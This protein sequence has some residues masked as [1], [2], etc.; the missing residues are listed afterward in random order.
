MSSQRIFRI[1]VVHDQK[2]VA[3]TIA[4]ALRSR[5]YEVCTASSNSEAHQRLK[6]TYPQL[7]ITDLTLMAKF[8][9]MSAIRWRLP[10]LPVIAMGG[11]YTVNGVHKTVNRFYAKGKHSPDRLVSDTLVTVVDELLSADHRH[12]QQGTAGQVHQ[13]TQRRE[14]RDEQQT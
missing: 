2:V 4:S 7:V 12:T 1:L 6:D 10:S 8:E 13:R 11:A 3:E 14:N 9:V 5:G